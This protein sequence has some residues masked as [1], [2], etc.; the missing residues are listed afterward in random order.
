M[1]DTRQSA[2]SLPSS[3]HPPP[4]DSESGT[5]WYCTGDEAGS[6]RHLFPHLI[7]PPSSPSGIPT[8]WMR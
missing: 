5:R 8:A 1:N 6:M 2:S 4:T 3:P 7:P